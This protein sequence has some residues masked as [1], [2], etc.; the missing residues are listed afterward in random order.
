M[1]RIKLK[2][3]LFSALTATAML[4]SC[5]EFLTKENPNQVGALNYFR[6]ETDLRTYANG[7]IQSMI[8]DATEVATGD[9]HADYLGWRGPWGFLQKNYSPD[10]ENNWTWTQLRNINYFLNNLQRANCSEQTKRHYEGVGRFW[11]AYFYFEKVKAYGAVPW[12][13]TVI[14]DND[15]INLYKPRDNREE[16]MRNVLEDINFACENCITSTALEVNS[17]QITKYVALAMKSRICLFEG[18]YRKYHSVDP[19][20]GNPWISDESQLYLNECCSASQA[21]MG[22]GRYSIVNNPANVKTQYRAL[23]NSEAVNTKE[24]IWARAYSSG[25]NVVHHLTSS[26]TGQ[27]WGSYAGVK[28]FINTYLNLDGTP[29]TDMAGYDK[30]PFIDE[31][32]NRDWRMSQTFRHPGYTRNNKGTDALYPPDFNFSSTGYQPIKWVIDDS[33]YD[34]NTAACYNS[35]PIIR[36]AE[37]LLNYAEAKAELGDFDDMIWDMTIKPLRERAGVTSIRPATPDQYMVDYFLNSVKNSD[38][39]EIRR[40]RGIE[41]FMENLRW[42]DCM[43]WRMGKLLART[44][45][46]MYVPAMNVNY[47]LDGDGKPDVCFVTKTPSTTIKGVQ[48]RIIGTDFQLTNGTSGY[49]ISYPN[50]DRGW[51]DKKYTH[52]IPTGAIKKNPNLGQNAGWSKETL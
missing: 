26:F 15:S 3:F 20:T 44:W 49:L 4:S 9:A 35:V 48:Y 41:L 34:G 28:Q 10:T 19:S 43:R 51:Q 12:Y 5:Q 13:T 32:K 23:F 17:V 38:I 30:V 52:P 40:E 33:S 22:C 18:T 29:F 1:K 24:V 37:I 6:N 45:H 8:P 21:L 14:E 25:L 27:Q 31:F 16:V 36:Y 11:R 7:F 47:D 46:G 2:I 50:L 39:L 42:D